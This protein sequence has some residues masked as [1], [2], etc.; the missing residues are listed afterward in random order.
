VAGRKSGGKLDVR[1]RDTFRHS[2][3]PS[4][5]GADRGAFSEQALRPEKVK[6]PSSMVSHIANL[7]FG[8]DSDTDTD[9]D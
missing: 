5:S 1:D 3:D 7:H 2:A 8:G 9:E 6:P 4:R